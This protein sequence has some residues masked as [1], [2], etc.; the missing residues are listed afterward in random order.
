MIRLVVLED[1]KTAC[2]ALLGYI[3]RYSE[4]S[5]KN[6]DV[7]AYDN[8]LDFIDKYKVSAD[9]IFMDIQMPYLNGMDAAK[10]VREMDENV[11]IVFVTNLAR[12]AIEAYEVNAYD[13]VLKPVRYSAFSM[14]MD[15]ICRYV[16]RNRNGTRLLNIITREVK[17]RVCVSEIKYVEVR[18][19]EVI[20]HCVDEEI[21]FRG[22]L[23]AIA[24]ELHEAEFALC[25]SCYLV[26]LKY[27]T[28]IDGD[29]VNVGGEK[30]RISQ[31]KRKQFVREVAKY[32]GGSE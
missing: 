9:V 28:E 8:A 12:Y 19:H 4:E 15:R 23:S 11:V 2:D 27:V 24:D 13:F 29:S 6:F 14:K 22:T 17:K 10:K 25:N 3:K 32:I 7:V 30:L 18:N 26:N 21:K 31:P 16:E 1:E 20:L 5:K